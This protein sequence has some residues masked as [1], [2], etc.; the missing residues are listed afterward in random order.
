MTVRRFEA[1]RTAVLVV[2]VQEKLHPHMFNAGQVE[3]QVGRLLDGAAV[4]E[5]PVLVTEQYRKGLGETIA[6][7]KPR[8][9][10]AICCEEKLLFSACVEPIRA[11]LDRLATRQVIVCGIEA[12][13]C[14]LQTTLELLE[15]GYVTGVAVDA[16]G[17]RHE[18]DLQPAV[19][20]MTQ[21]GAAPV[22][23]ESVLLEMVREAGTAR[24]KQ[25]LPVVK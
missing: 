20:R 24:F 18:Y 1:E 15:L 11:E 3:Q 12:H 22:T 14:V 25:M 7:L 17:C 8:L 5:L 6:S 4:L 2:D 23:V 19:Q 16:I 21:A 10:D 13:V 9:G